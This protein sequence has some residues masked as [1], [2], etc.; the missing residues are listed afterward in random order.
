MKLKRDKITRVH[1]LPSMPKSYIDYINSVRR[2]AKK[3]GIEVFFSKEDVVYDSN[4][5][6]VGCGGFFGE[7][8]N[9]LA[10]ATNHNL[11]HWFSIFIH[12]ACHMEQWIERREW[13]ESKIEIYSRFFEWLTYDKEYTRKQLEESRQAII[14]IEQDCEKRA[15]EKIKKY[16]FKNITIKRYVQ[17]ANCYLYLYSFML[18]RRKWY[19]S[20]SHKGMCWQLCPTRFPKDYKKIPKK[21]FLAF[22]EVAD[23]IDKK[24]AG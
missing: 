21:L 18:Q 9:R 15:V 1:R 5:D 11:T 17:E 20:V 8:L 14:E 4:N 3:H 24:N 2:K 10:T 16:K 6:N 12:E 7:E 22:T 13:F 19:N 23:K